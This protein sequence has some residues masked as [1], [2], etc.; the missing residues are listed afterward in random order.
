M[1]TERVDQ[2][3]HERDT[4]DPL[5]PA[6]AGVPSRVSSMLPPMLGTVALVHRFVRLTSSCL[7][8]LHLE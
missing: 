2:S 1:W 3:G 8:I 4:A 6:H 7:S 5:V